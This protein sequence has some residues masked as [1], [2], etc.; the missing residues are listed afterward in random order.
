[1][2]QKEIKMNNNE[3][4]SRAVCVSQVAART[5]EEERA[6]RQCQGVRMSLGAVISEAVIAQ[7]GAKND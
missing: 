1:M 6:R 7:F 2:K 5:A 4:Q 3:Q